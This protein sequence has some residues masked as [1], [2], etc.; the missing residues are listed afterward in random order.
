MNHQPFESWLLDDLPLAPEQKRELD[1][2]L[3]DCLRCA[4][5][6]ETGLSLRAPRMVSPAPGFA[7]RFQARLAA[8][9]MVDRRRRFW[10]I[11]V[12]SVAGMAALV[13]LAYP[14]LRGLTAAP[15]EWINLALGYLLF[16]LSTIQALAD[17]GSVFLRVLPGFVPPFVWMVLASA[18]AGASLL[19]TVSIWRI[20]RVPQGV[21]S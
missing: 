9:R 21:Q 4:S 12:F 11:F 17:V 5:L 7:Q 20:T 10:G 15:A 8:Q 3:R 16:I 14:L 1:S 18:L 6:A 2:H 19:W 13:L